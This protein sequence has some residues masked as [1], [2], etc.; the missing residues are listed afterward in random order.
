MCARV[1]QRKCCVMCASGDSYEWRDSRHMEVC[2]FVCLRSSQSAYASPAKRW[3]DTFKADGVCH[4]TSDTAEPKAVLA[5]QAGQLRQQDTRSQA[6]YQHIGG[7]A[8]SHAMQAHNGCQPASTIAIASVDLLPKA[9]VRT[10]LDCR[11]TKRT[12][13]MPTPHMTRWHSTHTRHCSITPR[14]LDPLALPLPKALAAALGA[15][16]T[17]C[18]ACR[19]ACTALAAGGVEVAGAEVQPHAEAHAQ[20]QRGRDEGDGLY[21]KVQGEGAVVEAQR[22]PQVSLWCGV[23]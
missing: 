8:K 23:T 7:D 20:Q 11:L 13:P 1:S 15:T 6:T 3:N 12:G 21:G 17:A 14:A 18:T 9:H 5:G 10:R 19:T 2:W 22:L 16:R 4:Q